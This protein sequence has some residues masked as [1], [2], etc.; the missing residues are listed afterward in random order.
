MRSILRIVLGG[1]YG[2]VCYY[3]L[4]W[5]VSMASPKLQM[6]HE[7]FLEA[8]QWPLHI[9][10]FLLPDQ[11]ERVSLM[12]SLFTVLGAA[13]VLRGMYSGARKVRQP[14]PPALSG[15]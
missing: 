10:R 5:V 12:E 11:W 6:D 13:L 4:L 1:V 15:V 14:R 9:Y 3:A 7:Q 8:L 2:F